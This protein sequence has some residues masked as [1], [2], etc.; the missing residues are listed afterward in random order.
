VEAADATE[1]VDVNEAPRRWLPF[2]SARKIK[3]GIMKGI[4]GGNKPEFF[5]VKIKLRASALVTL[6]CQATMPPVEPKCAPL[7]NLNTKHKMEPHSMLKSES[8]RGYSTS[9][10]GSSML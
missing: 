8:K 5:W 9:S 2:F 3:G 6:S 4:N 10:T 1:D 7:M